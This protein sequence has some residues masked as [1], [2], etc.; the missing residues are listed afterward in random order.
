M[1]KLCAA[2]SAALISRLTMPD[3]PAQAWRSHRLKLSMRRT[4]IRT[5]GSIMV[6]RDPNNPLGLP[7]AISPV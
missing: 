2:L 4:P 6:W 3:S 7:G 1:R 5:S